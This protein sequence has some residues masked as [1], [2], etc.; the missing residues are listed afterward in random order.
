MFE[1]SSRPTR[2]I[3]HRWSKVKIKL[4]SPASPDFPRSQMV[5]TPIPIRS[6]GSAPS[7]WICQVLSFELVKFQCWQRFN[8]ATCIQGQG[9]LLHYAIKC[10]MPIAMELFCD[11]DRTLSKAER[12]SSALQGEEVPKHETSTLTFSYS[13]GSECLAHAHTME[14]E[15]WLLGAFVLLLGL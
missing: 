1:N 3:D 14:R 10:P 15:S 13:C 12:F 2:Q 9:S 8:A 4:S 5:R 6:A 11:L 7:P